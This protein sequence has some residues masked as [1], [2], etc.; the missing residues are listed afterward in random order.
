M[1]NGGENHNTDYFPPFEAV[2]ATD[3]NGT[4]N[5]DRTNYFENVPVSALDLALWM[6]SDRMGHLL[7]AID[8]A[9]LNEQRGVVQNEK[10][11][12]ENEPYG[13][14][15]QLIT[16]STYPAGH[17]YSWTVIGSMDDLNAASLED[18]KEWFRTYYGAANAVLVIAGDVSTAEVKAKV[19]HY[20][21]DIPAGPPIARQASWVA[22]GTG[23]HRQVLQDRVPQTRVY[24][25]WNVPAWNT[26]EA[27]YLDLVSDVL[28]SGKTSRLYKRLVYD[29][30]SCTNVSVGTDLREIGGQ[31]QITATVKPGGDAAVV[32][33][34]INEEMSRF[35]AT[36]PTLREMRR[37]KTGYR[38]GFIRGVERIGGFG[39]KS[40]VLAE[41]EVF[42][43]S[44]DFYQTRL[45]WVAAATP[46][47]L[48]SA[49][50]A[51]LADGVYILTVEPFPD[52]AAA[53]SGADRSKLLNV[54]R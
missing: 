15:E 46:A 5:N 10:R 50:K 23:T 38:A 44:P 6:E 1:F 41:G 42:A 22:K 8:T 40:D 54:Q 18:V 45:R 7:G 19:E 35:L 29:D 28:G 39:G 9:K 37:V 16:E 47:K 25:V 26:E 21:G 14:T 12:G 49:A 48:L 36:G 27:T 24:M 31:F 43:G 11:E 2:G 51:W 20:F 13:R 4:T 53:T 34:A 52:F 32:E 17:P 33:R 3:M 30:Q